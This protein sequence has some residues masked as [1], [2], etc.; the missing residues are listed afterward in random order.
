MRS[1]HTYVLRV[2]IDEHEPEILRGSLRS[3]ASGDEHAFIGETDLITR[4]QTMLHNT[5]PPSSTQSMP[6]KKNR[7]KPTLAL[8]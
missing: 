4:L 5:L 7:R 6:S 8:R 3:V 1:V 2:L